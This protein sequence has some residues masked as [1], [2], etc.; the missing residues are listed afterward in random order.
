VKVVVS[1]ASGLIGT[2][3]VPA[4]RASGHDVVR[5]VR[6]EPTAADE[7]RW[8]P[9]AGQL[10]ATQLAGVDAIVNVSGANLGKRWTAARKREILESRVDTTALLAKTA[11]KLDPRPTVFVCAGGTGIYG[12]RGDEILTE[13]SALGSGFLVDVGKAWVAAADP[14][15]DAGMRVVTFRQGVVLARQGGALA[16]MLTPFRLGVAGRIGT[17]KQWFSWVALDDL[18]A[19]YSFALESS[20]SGAVNLCAPNPVTNE[21]FAKALGKAVRRPTIIPT[22]AIAIR[23]L[24]GEMGESVLLEGQRVLPARLMD[25]GFDFAAPTI[26]VALARALA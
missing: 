23:T 14:A 7:V 3:L 19:G 8:D 9:A 17:G 16:R 11:A 20:L 5:L 6:R 1:G 26:D 21:Q 15:R 10:D 24:Y 12:D 4:L 2:A 22:P 13:E 25:A 18:V